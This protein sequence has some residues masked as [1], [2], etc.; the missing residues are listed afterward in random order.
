MIMPNLKKNFSILII[1][2]ALIAVSTA[3]AWGADKPLYDVYVGPEE[4]VDDNFIRVGS[5][6]SIEGTVNGDVIVVGNAISISG[7]IL[8][9]VIAV[10]KTVSITGDVAG[11]VRVAGNTVNIRGR[12]ARNANIVSGRVMIGSDAIIGKDLLIFGGQSE[13]GGE[14]SRNVAGR[15]ASAILS[16]SV[17]G[18]LNLETYRN[19]TLSSASLIRGDWHY[20]SSQNSE[21]QDGARISNRIMENGRLSLTG[22]LLKPSFLIVGKEASAW[23]SLPSPSFLLGKL[24]SLLCLI[25]S[26]LGIIA[27]FHKKILL[28]TEQMLRNP[29]RS[30]GWGIACFIG[31]P[32]ILALLALSILGIPL[33]LVGAAAYAVV[34]YSSRVFVSLVIGE[35][36]LKAGWL[37]KIISKKKEAA[38]GEKTVGAASLAKALLLGA[39]IFMLL[40]SLPLVG[41]L[42]YLLSSWL[43]LGGLIGAAW[44]RPQIN[45]E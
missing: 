2:A 23:A 20:Y 40:A 38:S 27:L 43:M 33:A 1:A 4:L 9:D 37:K 39:I 15:T 41:P 24:A 16:G 18:D 34:L 26:G 8:G 5:V 45:N 3:V 31:V 12:I 29:L 28:V 32:L 30:I 22:N 35:L 6:V 25:I 21:V 42:L 7:Q 36:L 13:I 11:N 19:L 10:G 14:I 17:G 44:N